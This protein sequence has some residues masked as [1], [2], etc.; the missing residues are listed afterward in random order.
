MEIL[1]ALVKVLAYILSGGAIWHELKN[2]PSP[3]VQRAFKILG[4]LIIIVTVYQIDFLSLFS[5]VEPPN[6]SF[7]WETI[8]HYEVKDGLVKDKETGLIW[9]RCS[10]GQT[11]KNSTCQGNPGPYL[12]AD[13][14][15]TAEQLDIIKN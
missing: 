12:W 9:M 3:T 4:V 8:G 14:M 6:L 15:E 11:W 10:L 7:G 13:A 5:K 1:I 2:D